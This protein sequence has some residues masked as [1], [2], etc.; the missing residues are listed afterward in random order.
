VANEPTR[1]V[2]LY[3]LVQAVPSTLQVHGKYSFKG[4]NHSADCVRGNEVQ[5]R[6]TI[7]EPPADSMR[8]LILWRN[9]AMAAI[10]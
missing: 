2:Q 10:Q 8:S 7:A 5:K 1:L 3:E 4:S 6:L 9:D